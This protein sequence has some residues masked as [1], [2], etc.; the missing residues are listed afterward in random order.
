MALWRLKI[1]PNF[2]IPE[3]NTGYNG[4]FELFPGTNFAFSADTMG[5]TVQIASACAEQ[6]SAAIRP[7]KG[8]VFEDDSLS[9]FLRPQLSEES[10][11]PAPLYYGW[12]IGEGGSLLEFRAGIG[13]EGARIIGSGN[14]SCVTDGSG[15]A[16]GVE[17]VHGIS[18]EVVFGTLISFD[19]DWKSKAVVSSK[20]DRAKGEW[21]LEVTIPWADFGLESAP[22]GETWYFTVNR[23]EAGADRKQFHQCDLF[24][25]LFIN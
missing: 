7:A 16:L 22:H 19:Y 20:P 2:E 15:V 18:R 1:M 9:F 12:E 13:E 11:F 3:L 8:R 25:T 4:P 17:P 5:F 6:S 14:G 23:N 10:F 21:K 24:S